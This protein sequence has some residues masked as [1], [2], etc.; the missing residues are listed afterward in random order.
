MYYVISIVMMWLRHICWGRS[1]GR[2]A[3]ARGSEGSKTEQRRKQ[4]Q[5]RHFKAEPRHL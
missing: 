4:G 2:T 1:S 3:K 5:D